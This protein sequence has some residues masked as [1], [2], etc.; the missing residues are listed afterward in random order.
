MS[1]NDYEF[2][3]A[4]LVFGAGASPYIMRSWG[5]LGTPQLRASND[6]V[7][8]QDHGAYVG[9]E[10]YTG[11]TIHLNM[12]ARGRSDSEVIQVYD[13]FMQA[14]H[15]DSTG[16]GR[17][18]ALQPLTFKLPGQAERVAYGRPRRL[19]AQTERIVAG[20]IHFT[21]EF[22][23]P[24]PRFYSSIQ[25]S[26]TLNLATAAIGHGFPQGFPRGFGGVTDSAARNMR[27]EG[28]FVSQPTIRV[29]G[30]VT[31]P[32]IENQSTGE[33]IQLNMVIAADE[34][35]DINFNDR[36]VLLAGTQSRYSAKQG[37]WW[38]LRPGDNSVRFGAAS[39]D[40]TAT[41]TVS[42]RDAWL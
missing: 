38:T 5:G 30:P 7:R 36:S 28:S 14:W 17:E 22:Y 42:W 40:P 18:T 25:K 2:E 24:D 11:R 39:Y 8:P 41:A 9:P 19:V 26:E 20:L 34:Y 27:N 21:A 12:T 1:L 6:S 35:V 10:F 13:R 3:L 15:F 33:A 32:Y 16:L 23:T 31:N 4:G 29:R 37:S